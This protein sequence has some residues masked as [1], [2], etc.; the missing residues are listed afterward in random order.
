MHTEL[1]PSTKTTRLRDRIIRDL[2]ELHT[3]AK[4]AYL[5]G[6]QAPEASLDAFGALSAVAMTMLEEKMLPTVA[7]GLTDL[8]YPQLRDALLIL[9][10]THTEPALN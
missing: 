8:G 2:T 5:L 10:A 7:V 4:P 9:N 6:D 3:M 1:T